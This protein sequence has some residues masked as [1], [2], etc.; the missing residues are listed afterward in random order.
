MK[1]FNSSHDKGFALVSTLLFLPL[2]LM[3]LVLCVQ[4]LFFNKVK[5]ELLQDCFLQSLESVE[6]GSQNHSATEQLN[7]DLTTKF[8]ALAELAPVDF[9][10]IDLKFEPV[11]NTNA[12]SNDDFTELSTRLQ[13]SVISKNINFKSFSQSFQCG[14]FLKWKNSKKTYG[15]IAVKY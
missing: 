14:A 3:L 9:F 2:A 8:K 15:I 1:I 13:L 6:S 12:S 7:D 4:L 10:V 11:Q 5:N